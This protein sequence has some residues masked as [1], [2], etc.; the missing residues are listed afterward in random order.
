[1]TFLFQAKGPKRLGL[2]NG[3]PI[4]AIVKVLGC[5]IFQ[6]SPQYATINLY[7]LNEI[8]HYIRETA[9]Q[10]EL[11]QVNISERL[12]IAFNRIKKVISMTS[13]A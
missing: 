12:T 11:N 13:L 1:M 10:I 8:N 4:L 2:V 9:Y 7:L 3:C 6:W 5:P